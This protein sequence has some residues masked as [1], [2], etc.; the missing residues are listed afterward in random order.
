[1]RSI[2]CDRSLKKNADDEQSS[3]LRWKKLSGSVAYASAT[4]VFSI[5]SHV[6]RPRAING[7]ESFGSAAAEK[8]SLRR[9]T[10]RQ[11][12]LT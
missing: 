11:N 6:R 3:D 8:L 10:A 12:S 2:F 7:T 9:D 5:I 1:M 4:L